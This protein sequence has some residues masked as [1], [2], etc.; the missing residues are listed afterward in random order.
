MVFFKLNIT[1]GLFDHSTTYVN[2]VSSM[3]EY[4]FSG[5]TIPEIAKKVKRVLGNDRK[6]T[7]ISSIDLSYNAVSAD[8]NVVTMLAEWNNI[9][10]RAPLAN[11]IYG[12]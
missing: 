12:E 10:D 11:L 8:G 1:I 9:G 7:D 2:S 3:D 4:S 6:W 5:A